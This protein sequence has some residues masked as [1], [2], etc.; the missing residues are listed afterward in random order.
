MRRGAAYQIQGTAAA[1]AG[2]KRSSVPAGLRSTRPRTTGSSPKKRRSPIPKGQLVLRTKAGGV[3]FAELTGIKQICAKWAH[4]NSSPSPMTRILVNLNIFRR[5]SL[6]TR[7]TLFTLAI[8]LSGIWSLA[9]YVSRM[10]R[11]DM[12]RQVGEQ[13]FSTASIVAAHVDDELVNRLAALEMVAKAIMPVM[14]DAPATVQALLDARIM[15]PALF[16]SGV[17]VTD[18]DGTV[19]ANAPPVAGR[20][21]ANF[22]ERDYMIGALK[23]GKATIGNPVLGKLSKAPSFVMAVPIR[24]PGGKVIGAL[25][26]VTALDKPNFLDRITQGRYGRTGG[27]ILIA[28]KPR[29]IIA[30]TDKHRIMQPLAAPGVIPQT[31]RFVQGFE[32]YARY[33]NLLGEEVLNASK[34][35][36]ASDWN[37]AVTIPTAEAFAPIRAMQERMLLATIALTLLAAALTW[38]ML[39]RQFAPMLTAMEKLVALSEMNQP[40]QPLPITG[41]D[42]IGQ[43]IGGFN[44][45]L[46]TLG[47]REEEL[48]KSKQ[49]YDALAS[50]IP[51]GI[52]LLRSK[53]DG[54]FA[55]E[56]AS[57]RMAEMLYL[58]VD[59]LLADATSV[60]QAIHPDDRDGFVNLN[61]EGIEQRRPFDW[62]GRVPSGGTLRWLHFTSSPEPQED[63]NVLWFGLVADITERKQMED[64][65]RQ[66]AFYDELTKLP[67]RR[68]L[69][70]RLSQSMASNRRSGRYGAMM[71]LDLDDFKRLNDTHGHEL[72]DRLLVE[73]ADR[74]KS[75]IREMDTVARFGGD[76]F[77]VMISELDTEQSE[78]AA[79][80]GIIAEKIRAA[81]AKPYV[82]AIQHGEAAQRTVEHQCTASIGVALFGKHEARQDD[83]LKRADAA[84]YRAKAAGRNLV[85]FGE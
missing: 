38:W 56:Y 16:N 11:E 61:R 77:V 20:V 27:Y 29:L 74:L 46:Q 73:A 70:D 68:L 58:S 10:L 1:L 44:R 15:F 82:L 52:Y 45:L 36:P 13:L 43:L 67:N 47:K 32:G 8:F 55:L 53:P 26:G 31:D 76:E 35:V 2:A 83:I 3:S 34:L 12:Q 80:A 23:E 40:P 63:G 59:S 50:R 33:V 17:A 14:L 51:V 28:A 42:E 54:S 24:D 57:P 37:M 41:Q 84:M 9:F 6:K 69:N 66:L 48:R 39:R 21:G 25:A 71:F 72:G 7:V 60:L 78:S 5:H 65:V 19:V 18:L 49:H 30:A 79:Q 75:C 4:C 64:Q 81:L 85:R 62:I 22:K